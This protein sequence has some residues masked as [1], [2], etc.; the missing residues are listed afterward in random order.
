M[1][2]SILPEYRLLCR[3]SPLI[4]SMEDVN[5]MKTI[6]VVVR[7]FADYRRGARIE[8][9]AQVEKIIASN[10]AV[11]VVAVQESITSVTQL[12]D[13]SRPH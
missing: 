8:D 10:N 1:S 9:Q 12:A 13:Q 11:N 5:P 4:Y 6:L 7:D 2:R 3:S